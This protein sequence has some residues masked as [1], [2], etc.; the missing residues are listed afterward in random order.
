MNRQDVLNHKDPPNGISD[1]CINAAII[2]GYA[3]FSTL[4]GL[5]VTG[6]L[7]NVYAGLAAAGVAAGFSFFAS[8][9]TQ[10]GL[11]KGEVKPSVQT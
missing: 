3:F 1:Q 10:R 6:L 5:G 11:S 4:V 8:L 2:A 7:G 9:M